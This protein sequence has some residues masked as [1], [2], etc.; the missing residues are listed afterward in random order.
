M[1]A[2]IEAGEILSTLAMLSN[3][4]PASSS[5]RNSAASMS[6]ESRSRTMFRYSTRLTRWKISA[7]RGSGWRRRAIEDVSAHDTSSARNRIRE[8]LRRAGRHQPATQLVVDLLPD[9]RALADLLHVDRIQREPARLQPL[10]MT[11]HAVLIEYRPV[12][13]TL[14]PALQRQGPWPTPPRGRRPAPQ[15]AL[16]QRRHGSTSP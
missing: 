10:V 1:Y 15:V 11:R 12:A 14:E 6:S 2:S 4:P 16:R 13:G 7:A 8:R 9:R 5:G 3:P